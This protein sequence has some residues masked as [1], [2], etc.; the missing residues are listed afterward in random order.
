MESVATSSVTLL[1]LINLTHDVASLN[2]VYLGIAV[3]AVLVLAGILLGVFYFFNLKPLQE[4]ITKQ[5]DKIDAQ[6]KETDRVLKSSEDKLEESLEKFRNEYAEHID[7]LLIENNEKNVLEAKSQIATAE[8]LLLEKIESISEDKDIKL[9]DIIL[10]DVVN[11]ISAAE[12]TINAEMAKLKTDFSGTNKNISSLEEKIFD[13]KRS[14]VEFEIEHHL[15]K[16]QIGAMRKMIDK[17]EMDL[18]R[19]WGEDDTIME[20][21]DYIVESGMPKY[22][23]DD[24]T[25][26]IEKMPKKLEHINKEVLELAQKRLYDP[27]S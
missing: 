15:K 16:G 17:L 3:S 8:K 9:K 19:G 6:K 27:R 14:L 4:K 21:K 2:A 18:K 26:A 13:L 24:L 25:K 10:S 5:E 11:K 22:Y 1:D 23:L 20:I 7:E 12:K